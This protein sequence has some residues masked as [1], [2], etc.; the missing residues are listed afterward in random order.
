ICENESG[1]PLVR[2][3]CRRKEG[4]AMSLEAA[5]HT[6]AIELG[7]M[8]LEMCAKAGSGHPTTSLSLGQIVTTLMYRSMRWSPAFPDY[9]TSDRAVLSEGHALPI[10]YAAA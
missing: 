1:R 4:G 7:R 6:Q 10:V 2:P 8:S 5:I 3:G 9:P